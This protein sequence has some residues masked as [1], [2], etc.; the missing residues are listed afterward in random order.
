[1]KRLKHIKKLAFD[2]STKI[3]CHSDDC[4]DF[5]HSCKWFSKKRSLENYV[6]RNTT[7]ITNMARAIEILGET[8]NEIRRDPPS[9]K[10]ELREICTSAL[11][12]GHKGL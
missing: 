10:E 11:E 12:E 1:M 5:G 7:L 3:T 6:S 4:M 9:N 8:L 2:F